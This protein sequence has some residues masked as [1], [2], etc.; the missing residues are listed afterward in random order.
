[1]SEAQSNAGAVVASIDA[2]EATQEA[3]LTGSP[4]A[5]VSE[6]ELDASDAADLEAQEAETKKSAEAALK[7]LKKKLKIKVDGQELE[8]EIDFNDD[9]GLKK[10]LQK[11]RAFD[12]AAQESSSLK[13]Q[14]ADLIDL[15]TKDPVSLLQRAGHNV[16]ELAEKHIERM[17]E[18]AKKSPE[19]IEQ[20]KMR[21][22]LRLAKEEAERLKA[23]KETA[24]LERLRDQEAKNI[25]NE[26]SQYLD[27]TKSA[28]PK[29]NPWVLRNVAQYMIAAMNAGYNEVSVKDVMPLVENQFKS[30]L[31]E[32]FGTMPEEVMEQLIGKGNIDR[33]RK[34]RLKQRKVS[35]ETAKQ[36]AKPTGQ[37]PKKEQNKGQKKKS[38][39]DL[40][41]IYDD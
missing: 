32:M 17:I 35:T 23:E 29:N 33:L 38:Y 11:A 10:R 39:K 15:I 3:N 8:E 26:I 34:M 25:E 27:S 31:Q 19:Q 12:R 20:E 1:M 6:E 41:N 2:G 7:A 37:E 40:F 36:I 5:E 13:K 21:E 22:E 4:E 9:E 28:F 16:D 18:Q 14:M 30:D 24:E